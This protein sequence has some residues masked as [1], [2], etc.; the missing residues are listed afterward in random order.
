[1]IKIAF[2]IYFNSGLFQHNRLTYLEIA[3]VV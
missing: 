2:V 1:M 3:G